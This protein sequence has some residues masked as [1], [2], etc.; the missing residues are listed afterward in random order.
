M[1]SVDLQIDPENLMLLEQHLVCASAESFLL[2]QSD[3][4]YFGSKVFR[5]AQT[6]MAEG[7]VSVLSF[8]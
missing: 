4:H 5:A 8:L 6:L 2:L 7:R 1:R 3:E